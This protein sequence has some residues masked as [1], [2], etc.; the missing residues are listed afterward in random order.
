MGKEATEQ[1]FHFETMAIVLY[2][3]RESGVVLGDK[4]YKMMAAVD[5]KTGPAGFQ[6]RFRKANARA[7]ELQDQAKK[8]GSVEPVAPGKG[9]A[10]KNTTPQGNGDKKGQKRGEFLKNSCVTHQFTDIPTDR[11]AAA[12][13]ETVNGTVSDEA[14]SD[15]GVPLKKVKEEITDGSDQQ[16]TFELE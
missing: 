5:G 14:D 4:H 10:S 9:G 16:I 12:E 2:C 15:A 1:T 13:M 8:G 6:H 7:K 3:M 11:K